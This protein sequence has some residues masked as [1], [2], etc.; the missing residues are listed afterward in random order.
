MIQINILVT[1]DSHYIKALKIMLSSLFLNNPQESF[2]I[3]L[4][5]SSLAKDEIHDIHQYIQKFKQN[6]T[7]INLIDSKFDNSPTHMHYT[8]EMYYRLLAQQYLP[9]DLDR[10]LYLDPDVLV[11]NSI[12]DLYWQNIDDYLYAAANHD[13]F[14]ATELNKIRFY[15]IEKID[16]YHNTG[17]L[18]M[19]LKRIREEVKEEEI[20]AFLEKYENLLILPDQD[21]F[22]AL[23]AKKIKTLDEKYY[24]YDTRYFSIYKLTS[25][26]EWNMDKVMDNTVILHFCGKKKPW[27]P[28]Y[29]GEFHS[30]Y[31]HYEKISRQYSE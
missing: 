24:N 11:I 7:E 22:N 9:D 26:N 4:L 1:L 12:H 25:L 29:S 31:K 18:L 2:T 3:Y 16:A 27:D 10:I 17:V 6:F 30:L 15:P 13:V 8:K 19:N 21:I 20:F 28:S 23:Y 5:H 14:K